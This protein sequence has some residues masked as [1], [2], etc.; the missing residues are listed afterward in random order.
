MESN[1]KPS[2]IASVGVLIVGA[3]PATLGL[4]CN[5]KKNNRM[6]ILMNDGC[7]ILDKGTTL[8]GGNLQ[9]YLINSNT[10]SDGFL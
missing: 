8:G 5:A 10:S 9:H 4:F 2:I 7:A 3:G 6:K 1:P